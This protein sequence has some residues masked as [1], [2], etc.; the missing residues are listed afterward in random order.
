MKKSKVT[1][2]EEKEISDALITKFDKFDIVKNYS[3]K[4]N[5]ACSITAKRRT[6]K[7]VL[8]RHLCSQM[9]GWYEEV[10]VF[11]LTAHLQTDLF[12]FVDEK[13]IN[14]TFD[15]E[16]LKSIWN[17][18]ESLIMSLKKKG[19]IDNFPTILCIFDDIIG[20]TKVRNSKILNEYFIAGRHIHIGMIII[21]QEMGGRYGLPKVVRANL[22]LAIAF[23]LN[24]EG[25]RELFVKQYISTK[26]TKY[27]KVI[28]NDI[29]QEEYKAIC[30]LNYKTD[31]EP[32][33][34]I[35]W[36]IADL[37][38]RKFK[39]CKDSPGGF[40]R[41]LF[42]TNG[43]ATLDNNHLPPVKKKERKQRDL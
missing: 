41:E 6:G 28:F 34:Y 23:F 39:M 26:S 17:R 10:H 24:S 4:K 38:I 16:K 9:V 25:D 12:D 40:R 18:Q 43:S 7:S 30:I 15:E 14:H 36:F 33:N 31:K 21:S 27:G 11:S 29:C 8:M 22:D 1:I 3:D 19:Q 37:K 32:E 35:N 13:N 20:D 2:K 5:F 42:S